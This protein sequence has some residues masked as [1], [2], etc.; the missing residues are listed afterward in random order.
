M[1]MHWACCHLHQ[2]WKAMHITHALQITHFDL[3][4]IYAQLTP[5]SRTVQQ[6]LPKRIATPP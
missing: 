2:A 4:S 3:H 1:P 5:D 6:Y